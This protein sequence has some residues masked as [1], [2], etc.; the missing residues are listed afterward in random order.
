MCR[1]TQNELTRPGLA[2]DL[3]ENRVEGN[4]DI[5]GMPVLAG[6]KYTAEWHACSSLQERLHFVGQRA[7]RGRD[8]EPS[9]K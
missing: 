7:S 9:K 1:L 4:L 8:L 2:R 6:R 5:V 3:R